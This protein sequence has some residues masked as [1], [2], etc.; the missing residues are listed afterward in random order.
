[1]VNVELYNITKILQLCLVAK[2]LIRYIARSPI[3]FESRK[4]R[5]VREN[6]YKTIKRN[7]IE[8]RTDVTR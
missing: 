5:I 6:K 7:G 4:V 2:C 8:K 3:F 1:M